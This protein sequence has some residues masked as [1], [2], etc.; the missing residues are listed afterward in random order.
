MATPPAISANRKKSIKKQYRIPKG[1]KGGGRTAKRGT[2]LVPLGKGVP[3]NT[4][5]IRTR[6]LKGQQF[7]DQRDPSVRKITKQQGGA[8][9][10]AVIASILRK[11]GDSVKLLGLTPSA[12]SGD[13]QTK[14]FLIE[15]KTGQFFS[16]SG[17]STWKWRITIGG[18]KVKKAD[19]SPA[20]WRQYNKNKRQW[21]VD[22]KYAMAKKHKLKPKTIT[23][24]LNPTRRTVD[25]WSIQGFHKELR[26]PK[27]GAKQT[28][29]IISR[30][31]KY[32]GSWAY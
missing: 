4:G 7:A 32:E 1:Y 26:Y 3:K 27:R 31:G 8:L 9:G 22:R 11:Q 2:P 23:V 30:G 25:V 15:V 21:A 10:E 20:E 5:R 28:A 17:P 12:K 24:I 19:V 18:N 29:D 14:K 6:K 13:L 16:N